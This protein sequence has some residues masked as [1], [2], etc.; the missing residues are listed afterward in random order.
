MYEILFPFY[1]A[2][3]QNQ[4]KCYL[5]WIC[6]ADTINECRIHGVYRNE[7]NSVGTKGH[8][9]TFYLL[10]VALRVLTFAVT[11]KGRKA[12]AFE[13]CLYGSF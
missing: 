10:Y 13:W 2:I 5:L 11:G 9:M 12:W 6:S 3:K 7:T 8:H 1:T 4:L